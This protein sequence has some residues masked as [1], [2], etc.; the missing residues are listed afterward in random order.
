[1]PLTFKATS[2]SAEAPDVEAG[3]Y[4]ARFDG[5]EAKTLE[6]SQFDPEVFVWS[7]TLFDDDGKV[8]YDGGE[9][10][11]VDKITSQSTNTKART[12]PGAVK[13]LKALMSAEEFE[14]FVNEEPIE[15]GELIGRKVQ[16][17]VIVKDNGWPA[18]EEVL[19]AR[20]ARRRSETAA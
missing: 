20:R 12:T 7:F 9:P 10:V 8:L 18:V 2:K 3:V 1:V 6:K 11:V 16:L 13:V 17:Q 4:D 5:V 19:P 15:A 14:A